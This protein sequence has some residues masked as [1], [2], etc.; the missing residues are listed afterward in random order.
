[1]LIVTPALVG[2]P[3]HA[4]MLRD[5]TVRPFAPGAAL[6][7]DVADSPGLRAHHASSRVPAHTVLTGTAAL[8][9]HGIVPTAPPEWH[10]A[11]PRG[12]HRIVDPLLVFHSGATARLGEQHQGCRVAP[13]ARACLDALRWEDLGDAIVVTMRALD[14][15]AVSLAGLRASLGLDG[16]QGSGFARVRSALAAIIGARGAD[17]AGRLVFVTRLAS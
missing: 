10:V 8:W 15:D 9:V 14:V 1:M 4:R 6:P 12:L 3:A 16:P 17:Q 11:G 7:A 5:G 2:R 13:P